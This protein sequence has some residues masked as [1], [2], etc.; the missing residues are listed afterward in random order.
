MNKSLT[1]LLL[2]LLILAGTSGAAAEENLHVSLSTLKTL[3]AQEAQE[4]QSA[5]AISN[6]RLKG[7]ERRRYS[8]SLR[9]RGWA[10]ADSVYFGQAKVANQWGLGFVYENKDTYYGVNHR[11]IHVMRRL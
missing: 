6:S 1:S 5:F 4:A 10:I 9:V 7:I 2:G 11:G 3:E 8:G